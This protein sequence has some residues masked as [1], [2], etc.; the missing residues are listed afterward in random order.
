MRRIAPEPDLFLHVQLPHKQARELDQIG[1]ILSA[2]PAIDTAIWNDLQGGRTRKGRPGLA[3]S[4]VLRA[5][6]IKQMFGFSY[7]ELAFHLADSLTYRRFCG[8]IHPEEAPKKSALAASIKR[9]SPPTWEAINRILLDYAKD[10]G[11]D[12]GKRVRIDP[13]VTE[14]NIHHPTDNALLFDCVRKLGALLKR[15]RLRFGTAYAS[16]IKRAKRRHLQIMNAATNKQRLA[17]YQDLLKVTRETIRFAEA[18]VAQLRGHEDPEAAALLERLEHYAGLARRVVSQTKRR[19][20]EGESVPASEKVVSIFEP[21]TDIIRKDRRD[22][23]YG[24]KLTLSGGQS[25]LILDWV[26]EDG[27][28][29]DATLMTGMLDRLKAIYGDYPEQVAVDGGF[30]SQAN[31]KWA[32]E[33]GIAEISFA[34]KCGL[35]VEEMTSSVWIYRAL[36]NFRAGIEGIISFLKRV[37]GLR[38]CTWRGEDSFASY[39]GASIISANLL[40]LARHVM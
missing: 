22:T 29:A 16:R 10:Q 12:D 7:E 9:I 24:H 25:G 38:R 35:A 32:K 34:K 23:Y 27:N 36:R 13:T 21:H 39:V 18:A 30:A 28:P 31:L 26:V 8:L 33:Q 5:A 40:I 1:R 17:P 37:F 2:H 11:I 20:V 15:S 3:A 14:T 6:I 4:L 19:V